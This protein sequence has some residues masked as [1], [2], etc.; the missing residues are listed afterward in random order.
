MSKPRSNRKLVQAV[1]VLGLASGLFL[2]LFAANLYGATVDPVTMD[3]ADLDAQEKQGPVRLTKLSFKLIRGQSQGTADLE[4]VVRLDRKAPY[5]G[6]IVNL[7]ASSK[8]IEIPQS[9]TVA[10]G[11]D[12]AS[13]MAR[14]RN[15]WVKAEV[16]A[17]FGTSVVTAMIGV[18]DVEVKAPTIE[19]F[20]VTP[21]RCCFWRAT[22]M[23]DQSVQ[24]DT[25]VKLSSSNPRILPHPEQLRVRRGSRAAS[26]DIPFPEPL[27]TKPTKVVI[28]ASLGE[29]RATAEIGIRQG[30]EPSGTADHPWRA[31]P[32]ATG[33]P[34]Q[35]AIEDLQSWLD[36]QSK[37]QSS[38]A[39][40]QQAKV[41][42][43]LAREWNSI[44][45]SLQAQPGFADFQKRYDEIM[46]QAKDGRPIRPTGGSL[47]PPGKTPI[48]PGATVSEQIAQ[49]VRDHQSMFRSAS[50]TARINTRSLE[51]KLTRVY[52]TGRLKHIKGSGVFQIKQHRVGEESAD[53][54]NATYFLEYEGPFPLEYEHA[55]G[56]GLFLGRTSSRES[57]TRVRI[58][59]LW[60]GPAEATSLIGQSFP[61]PAGYRR[62]RVRVRLEY[63]SFLEASALLGPASVESWLQLVVRT[64]TGAKHLRPRF[65]GHVLAVLPVVQI[66]ER[67]E[68]TGIVEIEAI[69]DVDDTEG[70]WSILAGGSANG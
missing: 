26:L 34:A 40:K 64:P 25:I 36:T 16:K 51:S 66:A 43:A 68:E 9:V 67:E 2:S 6:V 49:L 30:S 18:V 33:L 32:V 50:Q 59:A 24:R 11:R 70:L 5:G 63:D 13:F 35:A 56:G 1:L 10:A 14:L 52:E 29:S 21:L 47:R 31:A 23:L 39:S 54:L 19:V 41:E 48:L 38:Q 57:R 69:I 20:T 17:S 55:E 62:V 7:S 28:T 58:N 12:S 65:I 53:D 42:K 15:P 37:E 22:I 44:R 45:R 60:A 27:P 8:D 61:L 46:K 3:A 4:G